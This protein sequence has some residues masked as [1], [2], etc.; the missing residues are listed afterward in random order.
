MSHANLS[1]TDTLQISS[2]KQDTCVQAY[3]FAVCAHVSTSSVTHSDDNHGVNAK[4]ATACS[5]A[6]WW[7]YLT[8]QM[9]PAWLWG[10]QP[11]QTQLKQGLLDGRTTE[12]AQCL[13]EHRTACPVHSQSH[14]KADHHSGSAVA[15]QPR[16][17]LE[18]SLWRGASE[19]GVSQVWV[20]LLLGPGQGEA[21]LG[22]Y[23]VTEDQAWC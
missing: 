13:G 12:L 20:E 21:P 7:R 10:V 18:A 5:Q 14:P 11:S 4:G 19:A 23:G 2:G 1:Q 3:K 6:M 22:H 8:Q 15:L 17:L 16:Q 9:A